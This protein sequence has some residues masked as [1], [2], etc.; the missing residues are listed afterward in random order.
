MKTDKN[1]YLFLPFILI[2]S[3][4]TVTMD[5]PHMIVNDMKLSVPRIKLVG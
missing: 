1:A 5:I 4:D 3:K 2:F